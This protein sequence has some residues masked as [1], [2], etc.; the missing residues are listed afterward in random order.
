MR[1]PVLV[2]VAVL[3]LVPVRLRVVLRVPVPMLA[4]VRMPRQRRTVVVRA[5]ALHAAIADEGDSP[6]RPEMIRR[7]VTDRL[8]V[9]GYLRINGPGRGDDGA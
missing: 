2:C 8:T 3:V 7:M 1:V 4:V 9:G 6:S 5:A